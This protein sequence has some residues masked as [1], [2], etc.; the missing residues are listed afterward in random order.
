MRYRIIMQS[1]QVTA[2]ERLMRPLSRTLT[3]ELARAL[4]SIE[5]DAQSR[6]DE[7]ASRHTDGRLSPE[8]QTD[9]EAI[10]HANTL[11]GILKAEARAS[12]GRAR[13]S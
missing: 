4:I 11:L 7:L 1:G 3:Q 13:P 6:Y 8:E 10:V 5:A 2:L 9:L 12:L